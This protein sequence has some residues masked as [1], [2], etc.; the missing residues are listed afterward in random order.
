VAELDAKSL[1]LLINRLDKKVGAGQ[2]SNLGR[3]LNPAAAEDTPV[4][5]PCI[6]PSPFLVLLQTAA[7]LTLGQ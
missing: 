3:G 7:G 2:Q 1:K 4:V 6:A 5:V